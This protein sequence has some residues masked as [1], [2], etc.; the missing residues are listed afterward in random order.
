[1]RE[2]GGRNLAVVTFAAERLAVFSRQVTDVR[3]RIFKRREPIRKSTHENA[4]NVVQRFQT[5]GHT[6]H[7]LRNLTILTEPRHI[8][9]RALLQTSRGEGRTQKSRLVKC[10]LDRHGIVLREHAGI[11]PPHVILTQPVGRE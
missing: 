1:M 7:A 3:Q 6:Q 9:R 8:M 5:V 11:P 10:C 2:S 4:G